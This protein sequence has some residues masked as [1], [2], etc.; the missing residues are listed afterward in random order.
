MLSTTIMDSA[1]T[2]KYDLTF[3]KYKNFHKHR[4]LSYSILKSTKNC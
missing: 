1:E 2:A 3:E 4:Y